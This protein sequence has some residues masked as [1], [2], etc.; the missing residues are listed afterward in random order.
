[1]LALYIWVVIALTA[2]LMVLNIVPDLA[3][4][5]GDAAVSAGVATLAWLR[6]RV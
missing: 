4:A 6:F 2:A 1:M 5:I 3:T